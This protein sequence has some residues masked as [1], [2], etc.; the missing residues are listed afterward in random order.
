MMT[1]LLPDL[2][3]STMNSIEISIHIAG[4]IGRGWSVPEIL[5]GFPLLH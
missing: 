4:G 3:N 5:I 1:D 2:G